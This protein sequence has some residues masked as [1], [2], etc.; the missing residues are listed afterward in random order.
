VQARHLALKGLTPFFDHADYK[1][2]SITVEI[3][4]FTF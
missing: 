4:R 2:N 3:L 1:R